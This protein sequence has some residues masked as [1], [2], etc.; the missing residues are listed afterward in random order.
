MSESEKAKSEKE[1]EQDF[2]ML[3][4]KKSE[5]YWIHYYL[6]IILLQ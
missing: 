1:T 2:S 4:K 6:V 3:K 5:Y